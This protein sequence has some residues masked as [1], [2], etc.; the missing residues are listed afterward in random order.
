MKSLIASV[1]ISISMAGC[2]IEVPAED[3]K[4]AEYACSLQGGLDAAWTSATRW[5]WTARCKNGM[6]ISDAQKGRTQ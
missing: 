1:L 2:S 4:R 3:W 5:R 6:L